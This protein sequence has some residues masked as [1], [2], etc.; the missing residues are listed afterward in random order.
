MELSATRAK[1]LFSQLAENPAAL[2]QLLSVHIG[3]SEFDRKAWTTGGPDSRFENKI[4]HERMNVLNGERVVYGLGVPEPKTTPSVVR[5]DAVQ[6]IAPVTHSKIRV[7]LILSSL[8][9]E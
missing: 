3:T 1:G 7:I 2:T 6:V 4:Q 9:Q 5:P 8:H